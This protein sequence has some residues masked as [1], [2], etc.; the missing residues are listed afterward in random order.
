VQSDGEKIERKAQITRK[1]AFFLVLS[2]FHE[3]KPN[4]ST[5]NLIIVGGEGRQVV[6]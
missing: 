1:E 3:T 4:F 2:E 5:A 6:Q